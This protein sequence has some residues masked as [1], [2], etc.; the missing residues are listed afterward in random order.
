MINLLT[1]FKNHFD[2]SKLSDDKIRLFAEVNIAKLANDG[3]G[4]YSGLLTDTSNAYNDF[5]V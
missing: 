1:F 5:L 2:T 4:L 3:S